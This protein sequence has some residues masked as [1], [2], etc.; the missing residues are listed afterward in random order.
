M[1][2]DYGG[3]IKIAKAENTLSRNTDSTQFVDDKPLIYY[4]LL[5]HQSMTGYMLP[6]KIQTI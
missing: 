4:L 2:N 5:H 3:G 6:L 1:M